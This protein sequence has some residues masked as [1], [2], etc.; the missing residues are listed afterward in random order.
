MKREAHNLRST[1]RQCEEE[2]PGLLRVLVGERRIDEVDVI[3]PGADMWKVK[4]PSACSVTCVTVVRSVNVTVLARGPQMSS[5]KN[6]E[7]VTP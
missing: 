6:S 2:R 7:K 5:G 3:R 1:R 4:E